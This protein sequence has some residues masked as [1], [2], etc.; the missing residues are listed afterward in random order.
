MR[1]IE[2]KATVEQ[3]NYMLNAVD[4]FFFTV[5]ILLKQIQIF[6]EVITF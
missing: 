3:L 1:S 6:L 5:G 4:F 2:R